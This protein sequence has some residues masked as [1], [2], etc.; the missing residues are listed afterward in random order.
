MPWA[1]RCWPRSPPCA[2]R[3]PPSTRIHSQGTTE[4]TPTPRHRR[5]RRGD[6]TPTAVAPRRRRRLRGERPESRR[7]GESA[8][9]EADPARR[10]QEPEP[11]GDL[12]RVAD[13]CARARPPLRPT[14]QPTPGVAD[15][16]HRPH[17]PTP[18]TFRPY[19][20]TATL[21]APSPGAPGRGLRHANRTDSHAGHDG[22]RPATGPRRGDAL[23]AVGCD[24]SSQLAAA[25]G[26]GHPTPAASP[27][28]EPGS[29]GRS[30]EI[31][32]LLAQA[33][34]VD[35]ADGR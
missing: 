18:T 14:P 10:R 33:E 15:S 26:A 31:D 21:R 22:Q 32:A 16:E 20:P 3:P 4:A 11:D 2:G 24:A 34:A 6:A 29:C 30:Y 35:A 7:T 5:R 8:P 9:P 28:H 19:E 1:R 12:L 25:T 23:A 17:V 27:R 13:A